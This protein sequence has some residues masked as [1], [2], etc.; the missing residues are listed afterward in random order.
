MSI[1]GKTVEYS[2]SKESGKC[3]VKGLVLDKVEHLKEK[4]TSSHTVTGY[5][6]E[7]SLTKETF[8]IACW[9]IKKVF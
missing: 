6:V 1:V 7:N 2:V 4:E 9:R 3:L 5:L 8:P